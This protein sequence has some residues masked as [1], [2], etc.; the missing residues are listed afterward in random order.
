[1]KIKSLVEKMGGVQRF[2]FE[3]LIPTSR[4]SMSK[5]LDITITP[6][7]IASINE[8]ENTSLSETR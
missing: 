6:V 5:F 1:M 3:P 8:L 2:T 7:A 4:K